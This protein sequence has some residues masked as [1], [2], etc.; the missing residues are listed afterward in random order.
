[1]SGGNA[2]PGAKLSGRPRDEAKEARNTRSLA[3][4]GLPP[5][6][7]SWTDLPA[8]I[9]ERLKREG[10][11]SAQEWRALKHRR[12]WIFGI[13]RAMRVAIDACAGMRT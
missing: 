7:A 9:L 12:L 3:H 8:P 11:H 5:Q 10:V 1:M 6:I 2:A 13:T 4:S